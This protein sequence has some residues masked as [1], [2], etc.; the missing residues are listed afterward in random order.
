MGSIVFVEM[1]FRL[2]LVVMV[3][4]GIFLKY[5]EKVGTVIKFLLIFE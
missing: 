1:L 4:G 3:G 5:D 2:N